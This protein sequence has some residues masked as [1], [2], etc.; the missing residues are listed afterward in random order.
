MNTGR[1]GSSEKPGNSTGSVIYHFSTVDDQCK[2]GR[3][4]GCR[5]PVAASGS[6]VDHTGTDHKKKVQ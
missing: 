5:S 1:D 6:A 4:T 2:W 3:R